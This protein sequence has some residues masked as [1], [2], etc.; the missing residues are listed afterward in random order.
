MAPA[1]GYRHQHRRGLHPRTLNARCRI[2]ALSEDSGTAHGQ[3]AA[4]E[5]TAQ[6]DGQI[7][8]A[9]ICPCAVPLSADRAVREARPSRSPSSTA[10]PS[11]T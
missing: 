1:W 6:E 5:D 10:P 4:Q 3:I 2:L 9:A 11:S 8:C 7:S